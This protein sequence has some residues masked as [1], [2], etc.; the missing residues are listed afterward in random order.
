MNQFGFSYI[1]LNDARAARQRFRKPRQGSAMVRRSRDSTLV[2]QP[3]AAR[4][5]KPR[6][7]PSRPRP[8]QRAFTARLT[9]DVS[10]DLRAR[11]KIAGFERGVT[12]AYL[13]RLLLLPCT[14]G[15][16]R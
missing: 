1:T 11:I 7:N 10:H 14:K 5:D 16:R 12:V 4:W 15:R 3:G 6:S 8:N 13:L 9:I 2:S